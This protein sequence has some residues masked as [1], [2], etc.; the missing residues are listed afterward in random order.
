MHGVVQPSPALRTQL[1]VTVTNAFTGQP[2]E[3]RLCGDLAVTVT[4]AFT[5]QPDE[6]RLCGDISRSICTTKEIF[7][8]KSTYFVSIAP[9]MDTAFVCTMCVNDHGDG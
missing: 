3:F 6:F 5:G 2:D 9:G 8:D 7:C 1:A 4:N